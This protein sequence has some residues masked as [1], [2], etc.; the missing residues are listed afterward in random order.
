MTWIATFTDG[1]VDFARP[2]H[3]Q[4]RLE[5][6]A[7]GLSNTCRFSGQVRAYY[8]V[9]E[10]A[11][12]V[13]DLV[14][15]WFNETPAMREGVRRGE[16]EEAALH[17]DDSEAFTGDAPTPLKPVVGEGWAAVEDPL[18]RACLI[19]V[20]VDPA[21]L[22]LPLLKYAD[23]FAVYYE[24]WNLRPVED[25]WEWAREVGAGLELPDGVRWAGG[26]APAEARDLYLNACGELLPEDF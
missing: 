13:R 6:V 1:A 8:S 3:D 2:A 11:V 12:F 19:A 9:A 26:L 21:L 14:A 23:W 24:A 4:I 22:E 25:G 16:A 15:A 20:G 18:Q 10:H 7:Q 5:D 17:H